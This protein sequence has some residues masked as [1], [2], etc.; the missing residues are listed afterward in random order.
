MIKKVIPVLDMSCVMCA[1]NVENTVRNL[2]GVSEASVN[3]A[4]NTLTVVYDPQ[5][6]NL[7]QIRE[8]VQSSGYDLVIED[9]DADAVE[10]IRRKHYLS[11]R[12]KTIGAWGVCF[13]RHDYFYVL[14]AQQ[15]A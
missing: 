9:G 1:A 4:S 15:A 14:Y 3:F 12:N 8:A 2:T 11:M 5:K 10:N 6:I 7:R 13:T